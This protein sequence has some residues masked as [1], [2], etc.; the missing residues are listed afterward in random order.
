MSFKHISSS[1]SGIL[2]LKAT[3]IRAVGRS[4]EVERLLFVGHEVVSSA[5]NF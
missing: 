3:L 1:G 5:Q 2:I 4:L